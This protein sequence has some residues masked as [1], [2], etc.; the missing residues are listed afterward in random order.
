MALVDLLNNREL[1][2]VILIASLVVLAMMFPKWRDVVLTFA[3]SVARYLFGWVVLGVFGLFVFWAAAWVWLAWFLGVW[4][5]ELLKD[6]VIIVVGVGF[7]LLFRSIK[8]DSGF[9]ILDHIRRETLTLSTM[10]LFYLNLESLPLWGELIMQP[11]IVLLTAGV[12]FAQYDERGQRVLGCFLFPLILT[13]VSLL[14]WTTS[15]ILYKWGELVWPDILAPLALSLWLPFAMF[16]YLYVVA[17]YSGTETIL[18]RLKWVDKEMPLG[19]RLGVVAGLLGSVRWAKR[20]TGRYNYVARATTFREAL[21]EMRDFRHDVTRR[22][23]IEADRLADLKIFSGQAGVDETGAQLDRREFDGTKE[24]LRFIHTAQALR[25]ERLGD[26]FWDDRTDMVI[27]PAS[28]WGLPDQHGIVVQTSN[29][30]KKWRAWRRLP[31]GWVLGIGAASRF[32]EHRYAGAKPPMT[33]PGDSDEWIDSAL[34]L[35][36][37]DWDRDDGSQ[38]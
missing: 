31:S 4:Q 23:Q 9:E 2:S 14:S 11:V 26:T 7:P 37:A 36:P 18:K 30:K 13:G 12:A 8:V 38:I 34:A 16:P 3:K 35:G 25:Y 15:Q 32:G 20:M 6:T 17:F 1:A 29:D 21:S 22:E 19:A 10:F 5:M 27:S 33:W 24:A 28:K